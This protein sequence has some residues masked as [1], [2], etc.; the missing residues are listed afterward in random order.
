M[1]THGTMQGCGLP[2]LV[3]CNNDKYRDI[4]ERNATIRSEI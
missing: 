2:S 4:T 1:L 3:V